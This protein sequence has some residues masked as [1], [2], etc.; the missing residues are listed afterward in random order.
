MVPGYP[1]DVLQNQFDP[2]KTGMEVGVDHP[3]EV[4]GVGG[5]DRTPGPSGSLT[6]HWG[7]LL[8]SVDDVRESDGRIVA[9]GVGFGSYRMGLA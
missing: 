8:G 1:R 2:D 4:L 6:R 7:S 5:R 3:V 9:L